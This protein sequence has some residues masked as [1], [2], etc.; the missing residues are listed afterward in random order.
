MVVAVPVARRGAAVGAQGAGRLARVAGRFGPVAVRAAR[1]VEEI[2]A[3][4][5]LRG[6]PC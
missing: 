3:G 1:Q 5:R 6:A 2:A 4:G